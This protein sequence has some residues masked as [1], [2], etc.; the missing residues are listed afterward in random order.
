MNQKQNPINPRPSTVPLSKIFILLFVSAFCLALL[1]ACD[2][3]HDQIARDSEAQTTAS[4]PTTSSTT[5]QASP[6]RVFMRMLHAIDNK[7]WGIV[8]QQ[9]ADRVYTDYENLFGAAP[10]TQSA[11]KLVAA[12]K[13]LLTPLSATQHLLGTPDVRI[14]GTTATLQASVRAYHVARGL[15]DGERWMVAGQYHATFTKTPKGWKLSRLRLDAQDQEGN[16]KLLS[17]ASSRA[18]K[19]ASSQGAKCS[20]VWFTSLGTRLAGHLCV[21]AQRKGAIPGV[22]VLGS[23]TTV[24]EQMAGLYARRLA[25]HGYAAL[26]FDPFGYGESGGTPR[27]VESPSRKIIDAKAAAAFLAK[28]PAVRGKKVGALG[29]CAGSGY[30]AGAASSS[31]HIAAVALVAPWLHNATSVRAIYGGKE[32]VAKRLAAAKSAKEHFQKTGKVRY[33]P[34]ASKTDSKA[35][36]F[37]PFDYYLNPKRGAISA[38]PNRFATMAWAEWLQFDPHPFAKKISQPVFIVHSEKAALPQGAKD[39]LANLKGPKQAHWIPGT[40]FHF[41]DDKATIANAIAKVKA[42]FQTHLQ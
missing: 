27:N 23:W 41:Y 29:I 14:Q 7:R 18:R 25:V 38:W 26:A 22:V 35:A 37:G 17:Q 4:Q 11:D 3:L 6:Q 30:I 20:L 12:W 28:H 32:G 9:L 42:H 5:H 13:Q 2:R 8:R 21:P 36:M 40:Q 19:L 31:K 34:A 15:A 24:K 16:R 39:F 33:V 1:P 10:V